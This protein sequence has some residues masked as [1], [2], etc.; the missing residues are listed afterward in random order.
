MK[1]FILVFCVLACLVFSVSAQEDKIVDKTTTLPPS[2]L[3]DV[4]IE[5]S[6]HELFFYY[7]AY[8]RYYDLETYKKLEAYCNVS[9]PKSVNY[10]DAKNN[11]FTGIYK[12]FDPSSL[13]VRVL[14]KNNKLEPFTAPGLKVVAVS[15]PD[16]NKV[17]LTVVGLPENFYKLVFYVNFTIQN[18]PSSVTRIFVVS[19]SIK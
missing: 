12:A 10:K 9:F 1:R 11:S 8:I 15:G 6:S 19:V 16:P 14:N 5:T 13:E 2:D 18:Q 17:Y 3:S 4:V 7:T